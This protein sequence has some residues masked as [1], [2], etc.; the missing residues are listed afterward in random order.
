MLYVLP[1]RGDGFYMLPYYF[2]CST[3]P[4]VLDHKTDTP[5]PEHILNFYKHE[6][7]QNSLGENADLSG[8]PM[9]YRG[10]R[11]PERTRGSWQFSEMAEPSGWGQEETLS[12]MQGCDPKVSLEREALG[13]AEQW[14]LDL[15]P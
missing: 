7:P 4:Q 1:S 14:V 9:G 13:R 10:R 5:F 12:F 2:E 11:E 8:M 6:C 15:R 3:F